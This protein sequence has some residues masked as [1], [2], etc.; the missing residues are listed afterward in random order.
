MMDGYNES[1]KFYRN[2][3]GGRVLIYI[4]E[5]IPRKY[6][7]DHKLPRDIEGFFIELNLRKSKWLLSD[8]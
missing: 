6:L 1:H 3:N 7:V 8:L 5:D 2:K 4:R